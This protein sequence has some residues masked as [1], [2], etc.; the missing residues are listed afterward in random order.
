MDEQQFWDTA[1]DVFG[2]ELAGV[3]ILWPLRQ[4]RVQL[5]DGTRV[6]LDENGQRIGRALPPRDRS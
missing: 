4:M 3:S 2:A 6:L 5:V 1:H